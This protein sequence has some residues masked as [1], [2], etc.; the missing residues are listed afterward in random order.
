MYP[1]HNTTVQ[2][3]EVS[4]RPCRA[5][6]ARGQRLEQGVRVGSRRLEQV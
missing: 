1:C 6:G 5:V 3:V 4:V 2:Q